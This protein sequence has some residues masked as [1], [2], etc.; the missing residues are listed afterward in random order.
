MGPA[1]L[2]VLYRGG[3]GLGL[4]IIDGLEGRAPPLG[5]PSN[6][7]SYFMVLSRGQANTELKNEQVQKVRSYQRAKTNAIPKL[8]DRNRT[9]NIAR[10]N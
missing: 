6:A 9:H 8:G 5:K 1:G 10:E 7:G 3:A 4:S 2:S